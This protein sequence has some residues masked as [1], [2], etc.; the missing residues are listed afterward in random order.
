MK[1][2][3]AVRVRSPIFHLKLIGMLRLVS[4]QNKIEI[5]FYVLSGN[6]NRILIMHISVTALVYVQEM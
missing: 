3:I 1:N 6:F 2:P 4:F 5:F